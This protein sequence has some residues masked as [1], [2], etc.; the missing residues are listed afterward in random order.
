LSDNISVT[1]GLIYIDS[2]NNDS[3]NDAT[4]VGAIRTT[5]SF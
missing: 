3:N 4:F 5:F 2:P 1:P